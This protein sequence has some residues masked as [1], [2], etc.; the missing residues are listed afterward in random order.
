MSAKTDLAHA[1]HDASTANVEAL[2]RIFGRLSQIFKHRIQQTA[3]EVHPDLRPAGLQVLRIVMRDDATTTVGDIVHETGMDK[4][5]VSRQLRALKEWGLVT[6]T[7]S[8]DDGRVVVVRP[9]DFAVR[10]YEEVRERQR[11]TYS[12]ALADW[13][14][15]DLAK[16]EEL[17]ARLAD[18]ADA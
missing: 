8:E 3:L 11:A 2:E 17:L 1:A 18:I 14:P 10:R 7:R 15:S 12:T 4:S 16:L 13:S 9:T 6:L 5:V